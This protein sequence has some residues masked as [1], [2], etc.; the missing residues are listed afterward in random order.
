M[1]K[2]IKYGKIWDEGLLDHSLREHLGGKYGKDLEKKAIKFLFYSR[3]QLRVYFE[4]CLKNGAR[5]YMNSASIST[6][7]LRKNSY[8]KKQIYM[9]LKEK[10]RRKRGIEDLN[11]EIGEYKYDANKL[12]KEG[13][14][15]I[16][17]LY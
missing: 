14:L 6:K 11:F 2:N 13:N 15:D 4:L 1:R 12:P 5:G 9:A 17:D 16:R 3:E 7:E 10:V 8:I